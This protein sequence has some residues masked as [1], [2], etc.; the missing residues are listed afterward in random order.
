VTDASEGAS[1][2]TW[3]RLTRRKVV[4][5]GIA[6][7]AGAWGLLQGIAY[8]R[9]TFGWTHS[10][11]RTATVLL[12]VGLPIALTLA[13]YHGDRGE[14]RVTRTELAIVTLLFLL[15]GALFWRYEHSTESIPGI[16]VTAGSATTAAT[17]GI[18]NDARPSIAVLP[19]ENRSAKP[20]DAF[21]VDGIHDDILT[22]LTKVG[23]LKV[24]ARTSVERF[25]DSKLTT[26]EIGEKLGVT[27]VLEGGVQRAGDRVR[28]TVQLIDAATDA[29]LWAENYDRELSAANIFAIQSEV[30]AAISA[31][32]KATLTPGEQARV[33]SL[34]TRNLEAWKDYQLGRRRLEQRNSA[35]L[36][37]AEAFFQKAIDRDPEFALAYVGLAETLRVQF[38]FSAVSLQETIARAEAA[39]A[40]ALSLDPNLAG[41][42]ATAAAVATYRRDFARAEAGFR[43]AIELNPSYATARQ[44][45]GIYLGDQG[46]YAEALRQMELAAELD[47]LSS[48]AQAFVAQVARHLGRY[49]EA[50]QRLDR[51]IEIDPSLA[52]SYAIRGSILA[53]FLN[54]WAEGR[55]WYATAVER[56]PGNP[57]GLRNLAMLHA[58]LA[59][60]AEAARW[61]ER[62]GALSAEHHYTHEAAALFHAYRGE[63]AQSERSAGRLLAI[64]PWNTDALRILRDADLR[65]GRPLRARVR[66]ASAYPELFEE[67]V[68]LDTNSA[69]AAIDLALVLQQTDENVRAE[70]LLD[71][72]GGFTQKI[73]PMIPGRYAFADAPVQALRGRRAEA[74]TALRQAQQQGRRAGWRYYRDYDPALASIRNDPEFKA[75]FADIERDMARQRAELAARPRNAPLDLATG[76]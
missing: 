30:A 23:A 57:G 34:P 24:I 7:A 61:V 63:F 60:D 8:M 47:P 73:G 53:Y 71:R 40:K 51:A 64:L 42:H 16:A 17:D 11:Q 25:R 75:V 1:E 32:L 70:L 56:D 68:A 3:A 12:L 27:K 54:R 20:E 38:D 52:I 41:A 44:W 46:R 43:K 39:A 29:H 6:Y 35:A 72:A 4:Q 67:V 48:R 65:A 18:S 37:E 5:W 31:A 74:L 22:Q 49:D 69:L 62:A 76:N 55:S 28:V 33:A 26:K 45:Y 2:S 66:Y 14:Q 50:L 9:D 10:I 36:A 19:F 13:W 59:D 58:E 21:F 15:G